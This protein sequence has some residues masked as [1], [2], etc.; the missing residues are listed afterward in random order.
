MCFPKNR[1]FF[2]ITT[3]SLSPSLFYTYN[4]F[5]QSTIHI[6]NLLVDI[7]M[8]FTALPLPHLAQNRIQ[9]RSGTTFSWHDSIAFF[10][11]QCFSP[12]LSLW[13]FFFSLWHFEEYCL[14]IDC[15]LFCLS[16]VSSWLN[17]GCTFSA[18][19]L[20]PWGCVLFRVLYYVWRQTVSI[21]PY[22]WC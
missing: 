4:T 19:T 10:N 22:W 9:S 16:S 17:W 13:H 21:C 20:Y 11:L 18:V 3:V 15:F 14:L 12:A 6:P 5:I 2:Y 7:I 1:D 8:P